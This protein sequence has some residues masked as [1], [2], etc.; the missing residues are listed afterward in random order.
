MV[1]FFNIGR[2]LD[3]A[4]SGSFRANGGSMSNSGASIV[5][6]GCFHHGTIPPGNALLDFAPE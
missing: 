6:S 2:Q 3:D 1:A 5:Q 4:T